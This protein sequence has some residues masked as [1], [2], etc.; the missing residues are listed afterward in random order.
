VEQ[1][2]EKPPPKTCHCKQHAGK[3][4]PT[5]MPRNAYA[6]KT[7]KKTM[8][9]TASMPSMALEPL[10]ATKLLTKLLAMLKS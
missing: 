9:Q 4:L 3:P 7:I 6:K 5:L 8:L 2:A 1:N 10:I